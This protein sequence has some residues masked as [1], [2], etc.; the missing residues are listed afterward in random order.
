M[1]IGSAAR[2]KVWW[3]KVLVLPGVL[4][5]PVAKWV[6]ATD[7]KSVVERLE[8]STPF[9]TTKPQMVKLVDALDLESGIE[10]CASSSLALGTNKIFIILT[11]KFIKNGSIIF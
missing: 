10:R 8:G 11:T 1:L 9:G 5:S 7:L 3:L 2:F 4:K 6:N